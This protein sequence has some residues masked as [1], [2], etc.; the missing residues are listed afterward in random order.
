MVAY[1]GRIHKT[2]M[3]SPSKFSHKT[4]IHV[5]Y[6]SLFGFSEDNPDQQVETK[7]GASFLP[8]RAEIPSC[9]DLLKVLFYATEI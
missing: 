7:P 1:L 9:L 2:G 4:F 5:T 8:K 3:K 6:D